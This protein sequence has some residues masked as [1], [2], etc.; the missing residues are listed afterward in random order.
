MV[1]ARKQVLVQL[2][3]ELVSLLDR[4]ARRRRVS[5]SE[6]IREAIEQH[7]AAERE[8]EADRRYVE[9][10]TRYPQEPD[11]E[12]DISAILAGR[13]MDEEEREAGLEPW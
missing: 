1:V 11:P 9:S 7:T 12:A 10:Y 5:R 3:D 4:M 2:S 8:T 6:L 13:A